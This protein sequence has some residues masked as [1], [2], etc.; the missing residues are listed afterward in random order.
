MFWRRRSKQNIELI[1]ALTA[2]HLRTEALEAAVVTIIEGLEQ[3]QKPRV[4]RVIQAWPADGRTT[5][6]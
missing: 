1:A 5:V 2:L 6:Q 4:A 3:Q